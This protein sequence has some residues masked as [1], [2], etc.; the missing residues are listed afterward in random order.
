MRQ[1]SWKAILWALALGLCAPVW[2]QG[3]RPFAPPPLPLPPAPDPAPVVAD[4]GGAVAVNLAGI[5]DW[6][7]QAPFLDLMKTSRPWIGHLADRSGVVAYGDLAEGGYLDT[8]GW[9][10][11]IPPRLSSIGTLILTDMPESATTLAGRYL[12]R[13][14]GTGIVEVAGRARNAH[15]R[16]NEIRFDYTPGPGSVD[17]RIQ[18]TG[19]DNGYVRNITVVREDRAQAHEAGQIF[20]PDWLARLEPFGVLRFMDWIATNGSVQVRWQDRPR[21]TD[22]TYA[23]RGVP[24]EVMV[25]LARDLQVDPWFT[26]PH[27]A[28]DG[29]FRSFAE[30]V[31]VL[32]PPDL[33][34]WAEFSNE[35]WNWEYPQA[36]WA[37]EE[38]RRR[39]NA[40]EGWLQAYAVR[41]AEMAASWEE[42]FQGPDR[43]RL[44]TV[45]S[46][47]TGWPGIEALILDPPHWRATQPRGSAPLGARFDAYAVS[48]Y[49]GGTLGEE[50]NL[51]VLKTWLLDS[52]EAAR[53]AAREAGLSGTERSDYV[54]AH[55]FDLAVERAAQDL[56]DGTLT[57]STQGTLL[58]LLGTIL[59][60]HAQI[61]RAYGLE[62]VM[63]EGGTRVAGE[64][65]VA[66]DVDLTA[67]FTHLNYTDAM[68]D[69]YRT[70]MDGWADLGGM[71][72]NA[73]ADVG[74][75]GTWGS[76]GHLRT[77][78]DDN[79]RWQ[80][81]TRQR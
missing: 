39:W 79:P 77:L 25:A 3:T 72:F 59:P 81:L 5:A 43:A 21:A 55:R 18:R 60:H 33:K 73:Y 15:Y 30:T 12:L 23:L 46:T 20:N 1:G 13:F 49:F 70:L 26:L 54:I 80:A 61:A 48:G 36:A 38:A 53:D 69:L 44:K 9:P 4:A 71:L 32:A 28:D 47:Q 7:T 50:R 19:G 64:G 67:F 2:A 62:L 34:I 45:I 27:A 58:Q 17:I 42:V 68:G 22:V 31:H 8:G 78:S 6:S 75:P 65:V 40:G 24:V 35:V 56:V 76:W 41:A 10:M 51:P 29:Y 37:D 57:G 74:W 16:D 63:Y 52:E 11:T 66:D 14:E